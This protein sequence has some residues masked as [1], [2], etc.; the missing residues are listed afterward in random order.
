MES[1]LQA[2]QASKIDAIDLDTTVDAAIAAKIDAGDFD[3]A[4]NA[5][6]AAKID[7]AIH[8][9]VA[10]KFDPA[11]VVAS[12][13]DAAVTDAIA[14]KIDAAVA[15]IAEEKKALKAKKKEAAAKFDEG[16]GIWRSG[17][18]SFWRLSAR[19]SRRDSP[20]SPERGRKDSMRS[21]L[22]VLSS[23]RW[24]VQLLNYS[25]TVIAQHV[26]VC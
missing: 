22:H 23:A 1:S 11:T 8:A 14:T 7:A 12:R 21:A 26:L 25:R 20:P 10:A 5:A 15:K 3:D 16:A 2:L 6:I 19:I 18:R 4:V 17:R 9:A 24:W 13:I